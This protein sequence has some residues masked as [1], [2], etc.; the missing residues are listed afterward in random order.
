MSVVGP[1]RNSR[2]PHEK[3]ASLIG[4]LGS[5]ALKRDALSGAR[6]MNAHLQQLITDDQ[7][8][9]ACGLTQR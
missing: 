3:S 2:L 7:R 4:R 6:A 1:K 9:I 8:Q 5:S